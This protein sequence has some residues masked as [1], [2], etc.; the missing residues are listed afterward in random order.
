[1]PGRNLPFTLFS[2]SIPPMLTTFRHSYKTIVQPENNDLP[3]GWLIDIVVNPDTGVF[4]AFWVH[5]VEGKKLLLP[6]DIIFWDSEQITINDP[7]DLASPEDLPR[8]SKI[9]EQ[10]CPILKATVWDE[11]LEKN[12]GKV[13]DFTFDTISPRLLA[14]EIESG[15]LGLKSQRIPQHR[16]VSIQADCIVV[17]SAALKTEEAKTKLSEKL[18]VMEVPELE[19]P[20]R[21][22]KED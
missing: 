10:E 4:E 5:A 3:A 20:P 22:S 6:K 7:Q 18:P 8:L 21:K 17:D 19:G 1:M 15:L 12:I 13:C 2:S 9:F 11:A 14:L 16:I